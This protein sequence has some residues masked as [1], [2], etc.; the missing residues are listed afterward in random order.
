MRTTTIARVLIIGLIVTVGG[1][2]GGPLAWGQARR[3]PT[4]RWLGQDGKDLVGPYAEL[5]PS[6]VQDVH[7]ALAGLPPRPIARV[8][9]VG[10]G[11]G[12]WSYNPVAGDR[13]W[14]AELVRSPATAPVASIFLE[15]ANPE[16]GRAWTITLVFDDGRSIDVPLQGGRADPNR[17][18]ASAALAAKW[19]GQDGRDRAGLSPSVGPDGLM[20][21]HVHLEKLTKDAEVQALRITTS[22]APGWEFGANPSGK[23][24]AELLRDPSDSTRADVFFQPDRNLAGASLTIDL[25]Y[26]G[27]KTDRATVAASACDPAKTMPA[28]SPIKIVSG[29]TAKW[30]G[31][32]GTPGVEAGSV[33]VAIEGLP[34]AVVKAV[35]L[36]GG[37]RGSWFQKGD[38]AVKDAPE[39]DAAPLVFKRRANDPTRADLFFAPE[40][41]ETGSTMCLRLALGDGSHAVAFFPGGKADVALRGGPALPPPASA[42]AI[43]V[44]PGQDLHAAVSKGGAVRIVAGTYKLDRP[45]W[46]PA[47]GSLVGEPGA[48]LEFS[49]PARSAPW[50][51]AIGVRG[52]RVRLEGFA[53]RF[54]GPVRWRENISY[55]PAVIGG[56]SNLD[57]APGGRTVAELIAT[58]LDLESPPP[59]GPGPWEESVNLMRLTGVLSG[60][61][62]GNSLRGGMIEFFGG[63]WSIIDNEHRG[64][65]PRTFTPTMLVGHFTHDAVIR[66]N[67]TKHVAPAGKTWRFLVLTHSGFRDLIEANA[68]TGVGPRDDDTISDMNMPEIVLTEAYGLHFEGK[69]SAVSADG[70][71]VQ[72]RE[73][74]GD[75]ART[76]AILAQ[77]DGPRAGMWHRV[78]QT[79]DAR[80]YLVDPPLTLDPGQSAPTISV[81]TGFVAQAYRSNTIE[82]RGAARATGFVL[83]GNHY[84]MAVTGNTVTGPGEGFRITSFASER[85]V[86]WGWSHNPALSLAIQGNTARDCGLGYRLAVDH[87]ANIKSN[88]GRVYFTATLRDN[89]AVA[90]QPSASSDRVAVRIGDPGGLDPRE[91][92]VTEAG[93]QGEGQAGALRVEGAVLNGR[94]VTGQSLRLSDDA[95]AGAARSVAPR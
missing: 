27:G 40:R 68:I 82:A 31:Q 48:I 85:P 28:P 55:G 87:A 72:V 51:E 37:A 70:R 65:H 56:P 19:L 24:N 29:V 36:S 63:P 71:V 6:D 77:L 16:R 41:D 26:N 15:V 35:A 67:R 18:M 53:V 92:I 54:S 10:Q 66:G 45:L 81:A 79:I 32:D 22:G 5:R 11:G 38:P 62:E 95:T 75:P 88:A 23:F 58:K 17:R 25:I 39:P 8:T 2:G 33:R 93:T 13:S 69:P 9:V 20:D 74:Q 44:R 91:M 57:P 12:Q 4:A 42:R 30:L 47:S 52:G 73:P 59:S 1:G 64:T 49:Q 78:A 89:K 21:V 7:I 60:R 94:V 84:G 61:I 76:G 83:V 50:V 43:T 80:T 14:R 34:R 46:L 90:T 3:G 86:H